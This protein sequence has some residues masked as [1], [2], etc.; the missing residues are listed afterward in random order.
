[1]T[2]QNPNARA[3]Y[4]REWR[5]VRKEKLGDGAPYQHQLPIRLNVKGPK[6]G[7]QIAVIPD[8]Q[9]RPGVPINHLRAAGQ[10][11]A[12]K[13]PDVV[14]CIGDFADMPSL[15]SHDKPGT[16]KAEGRRY[17]ADLDAAKTGM[18]LLMAPIKAA[19]AYSPML[20]MT[21]GNH[22]DRIT[23]YVDLHPE[24]LEHTRLSDLR[25]EQYGWKVYPF[26]QPVVIGGV[27]FCHY[28][29]MGKRGHA[30]ESPQ[31]ILSGL[32]MSA[33]AGHQQGRQ[34]AYSPKAD[35]GNLTAIISGSFY[36]HDEAYMPILSNRHWR[37]MWFLNEV[38]DGSFDEMALSV[39]YL[40]RR[41][42]K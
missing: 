7:L 38:K 10:Y 11:I 16:L 36:Q 29:P 23:R 34:I 18:D 12:A 2:D 35:G 15:S 4:M 8:A 27:V 30:A 13:Q 31:R 26:L 19:K 25:Y 6:H 22:E 41:F 21:L 39:N 32:H 37:G 24:M 17:R 40:L 9:V 14:V 42:G 33:F 3:L 20:V 5:R 1:M 28:F